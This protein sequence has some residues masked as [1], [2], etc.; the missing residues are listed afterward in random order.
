MLEL[1]QKGGGRGEEGEKKKKKKTQEE[2]EEDVK[3]FSPQRGF[4]TWV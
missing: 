2:D 4:E 1:G 3:W